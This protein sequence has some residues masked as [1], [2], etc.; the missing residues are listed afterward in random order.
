MVVA[1][2]AGDDEQVLVNPGDLGAGQ[3]GQEGRDGCGQLLRRVEGQCR[4]VAPLGLGPEP[5]GRARARVLEGLCCRQ[6]EPAGPP[7]GVPGFGLA[8][9][10]LLVPGETGEVAAPNPPPLLPGAPG[11]D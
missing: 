4:V 10:A 8:V 7:D 5:P 6:R 3:A 2:P 9:Q 1:A 11:V